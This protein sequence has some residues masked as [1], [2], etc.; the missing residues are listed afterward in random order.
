VV[1]RISDVDLPPDSDSVRFS[2]QIPGAADGKSWQDKVRRAEDLGFYSISVP[3]HLSPELPQLAPFAALAAASAVSSRVRLAITVVNNDFRHPVLVAK[4]VATI[5]VLSGGRVDLGM[6]AG[7]LPADYTSSGVRSWD[8]AG[9]RVSRL[10]E[11]ID[12]LRQLL[13]GDAVTFKGQFYEVTEFMSHPRPLQKS[14]PL[15]IGGSGRRMLAI[16][17]RHADIISLIVNNP[18]ADSSMRAF[19]ERLAWIAD[20]GGRTRPELTLGVRVV[21]GAVSNPGR[22]RHDAAAEIASARG[23]TVDDVLDSPFVL[24]GDKAAIRDRIVELHEQYGVSYFTLSE[25]FAWQVSDLVAELGA[26]P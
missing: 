3:D 18:Q 26:P 2:I 23:V 7:W 22:S 1:T 20:A 13:T 6:G 19:A 10:E 5:D 8:P 4:E 16:A 17:A 9:E 15:M 21:M 12:L 24:V 11:A 14:V 25:N